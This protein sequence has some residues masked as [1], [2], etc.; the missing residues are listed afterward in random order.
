MSGGLLG[1]SGISGLSTAD[2]GGGGWNQKPPGGEGW[3]LA[4]RT[5]NRPFPGSPSLEKCR[6]EMRTK[7]E[8][9]AGQAGL[10]ASGGGGWQACAQGPHGNLWGGAEP[11]WTT[12]FCNPWGGWS[13]FPEPL[14]R[15]KSPYLCPPFVCLSSCFVFCKRLEVLRVETGHP[16]PHPTVALPYRPLQPAGGC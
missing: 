10:G 13:S 7:G 8:A 4:V 15:M 6:S 1:R 3:F 12:C 5:W 9:G 14:L 16:V 11:V 2:T